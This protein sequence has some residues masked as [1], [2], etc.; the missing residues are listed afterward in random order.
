MKW[1]ERSRAFAPRDGGFTII[2]L[3]VSIA[4]LTLLVLVTAQIVSSAASVTGDSRKHMDADSQARFVFDR[5]ALDFAGLV[6]RP[7]VDYLFEKKSGDDAMAFYSETTGYFPVGVSGPALKSPV[8]LAGYRM[9]A[10]GLERLGKGLVWNGA[11]VGGGGSPMVYLPETVGGTWPAVASGTDPD[12]QVIG[13]QVF[14]FEYCF[15]LRNE[16]GTVLSDQPWLPTDSGPNGMKDV[17][18]IVVTIAVLDD[19]SR[20]ILG[21]GDLS[22]AAG[23]FSDVTGSAITEGPAGGWEEKVNAGGLGLPNLAASQVRI[24]QRFFPIN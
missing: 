24:Y 15:L 21:T 9:G 4:V 2:E 1:I 11:S 12:Y 13:D 7:D 17:A 16:T 19:T 8:A 23:N 20:A 18:A 5:M 14:R 22:S 10:D 3:L 6:R